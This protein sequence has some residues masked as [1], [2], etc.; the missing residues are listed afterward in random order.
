MS[1]EIVVTT[2]LSLPMPLA[3]IAHAVFLIV[4]S[5]IIFWVPQILIELGL[6]AIGSDPNSFEGDTVAVLAGA[7]SI[8]FVVWTFICF[9]PHGVM[10]DVWMGTGVPEGFTF[11]ERGCR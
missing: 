10:V 6:R 9:I 1:T 7:M 2:S 3:I 4:L 5:A 8:F 11:A